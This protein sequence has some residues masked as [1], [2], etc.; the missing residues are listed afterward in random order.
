[1][2]VEGEQGQLVGKDQLYSGWNKAKAMLVLE[3]SSCTLS[4]QVGVEEEDVVG[5]VEAMPKC[6]DHEGHKSRV[7]C[8]GGSLVHIVLEPLGSHVVPA[9]NH[10][11][12]RIAKFDSGDDAALDL[13]ESFLAIIGDTT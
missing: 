3:H 11:L 2:E 4:E 1:M 13:G 7:H 10:G 9:V 8:L 12:G 5:G 6:T